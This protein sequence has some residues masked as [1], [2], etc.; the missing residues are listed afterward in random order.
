MEPSKSFDKL[1]F[2]LKLMFNCEKENSPTQKGKENNLSLT[3]GSGNFVQQ[4]NTINNHY[5]S[6]PDN[7]EQ[8]LINN[9]LNEIE[10]NISPN[11][12]C[13]KCHFE[14]SYHNSLL[15]STVR[16]DL[17]DSVRELI[18]YMKLCNAYGTIRLIENPPGSVKTQSKILK[19]QLKDK[20]AF[21]KKD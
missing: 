18:K 13:P 5:S 8:N 9:L 19:A 17:H 4:A 3:S 7:S 15:N 2:K 21:S 12:G 14:F 1:I 20:P 6:I 10:Y 16:P 11:V